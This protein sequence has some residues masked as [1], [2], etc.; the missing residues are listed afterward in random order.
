MNPVPLN[1]SLD[2][3]TLLTKYVCPGFGAILSNLTFLAPLQS[4][5]QATTRGSLGELNTLPFAIMAGCAFGWT[6]YG[7]VKRDIFVL[8]ANVPANFL[9][10]WYNSN[11]IKLAYLETHKKKL[12]DHHQRQLVSQV[13][14]ENTEESITITTTTTTTNTANEVT[15]REM[16]D[17]QFSL[18]DRLLKLPII[19]LQEAVL[20]TVFFIWMIVVSVV[21]MVSLTRT[22]REHIV[23]VVANI[24]LVIFYASPLSTIRKVVS[25][26]DS[27]SIHRIL[28]IM[29]IFN[30][31]FWC[32]YSIA[33]NDM[34]LFI[35]NAIGFF[36]GVFQTILCLIYPKRA[37]STT[38][39]TT[40]TIR[41][42]SV[43]PVSTDTHSQHQSLIDNESKP[44]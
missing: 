12:D 7:F 8:V 39:S 2:T 29:M 23:G 37:D 10:I 42:D 22:E 1:S 4:I 27:S 35:P 28:L 19:S 41:G 17:G 34:I 24:N 9:S 18:Q 30:S 15:Q 25:T 5:I 26:K 6:V 14:N 43:L 20:I 31:V 11:A 33:I 3:G 38:T 40:S 36:F 21:V 44:I 16:E 32:I 13:Q